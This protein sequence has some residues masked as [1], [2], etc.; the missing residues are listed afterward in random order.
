MDRVARD[1]MIMVGDWQFLRKLCRQEMKEQQER[2]RLLK[3][4]VHN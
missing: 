4:K 2:K 1:R 3:A